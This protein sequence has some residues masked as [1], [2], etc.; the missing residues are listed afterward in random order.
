MGG[1]VTAGSGDSIAFRIHLSACPDATVHLFLDG[2]ETP[3]IA[4]LLTK[5]GDETLPFAWTSDG[6]RHWVRIEVRDANGGVM[7]V[8]NPIYI[9]FN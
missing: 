5:S 3:A 2:H 1:T 7:L 9:N 6:G 4:P 8:S